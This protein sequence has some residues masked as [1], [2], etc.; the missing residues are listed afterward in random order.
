MRKIV[1][2]CDVISPAPIAPPSIQPASHMHVLLLVFMDVFSP[3]LSRSLAVLLL[4]V[5][6]TFFTALYISTTYRVGEEKTTLPAWRTV[7]HLSQHPTTQMKK[8][9]IK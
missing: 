9:R 8:E 1:Q 3:F 4:I 7:V 5:C 2:I 6:D